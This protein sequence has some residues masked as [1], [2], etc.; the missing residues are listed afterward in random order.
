[1]VAIDPYRAGVVFAGTS[2][3]L[4]RSPDR[5][6]T[7]KVVTTQAV[8]S[9]AFD[10]AHHEKIFFASSTA[11]MLL[12]RDGGRTVAEFN[13]GFSNRNFTAVAAAGQALYAASVYEPASGGIFRTLNRGL[14]WERLPGP[15][16]GENIVHLAVAPDDQN[17]LYASGYAGM[18]RSADGG[19]TW[20]KPV[21]LPDSASIAA[22]APLAGG[23]LLAGGASGLFAFAHES[24]TPIEMPGPPRAIEQLQMSPGD[25]LAA[26]STSGALRSDD[27]GATW[28]ACGD[29]VSGAVWY[30]LAFDN[31]SS[32]ALAATSRGLY[33]STDRCASW[34]PVR[35]GLEA[36]TVSAVVFHPDRRGTAFAAQGGRIFRTA[37]AGA[38]WVP[39]ARAEPADIY[40][41]SL[42]FLFGSP[43]RIFG[44]FPRRG[45]LSHSIDATAS[46][47]PGASS[48][49]NSLGGNLFDAGFRFERHSPAA[50]IV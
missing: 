27:K 14:R 17:L 19:V 1:M 20:T 49:S 7:W 12:S 16:S 44:L 32:A 35:A 18:F 39:L 48:I 6:S 11:G 29:V 5:G 45:V 22:M 24:W 37:D 4:L 10:T 43:Q 13:T 47:T 38:T 46:L 3:G 28:T 50:E 41:T 34:R 15:K 8:K 25:V 30:G 23:K 2:A 9:I 26:L 40:P 21:P 33:R 36:A 31:G 42:F